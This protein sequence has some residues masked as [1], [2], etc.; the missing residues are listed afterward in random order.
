MCTIPSN[1]GQAKNDNHENIRNK[2]QNFFL[3]KVWRAD[4]IN[5]FILR[6]G[7]QVVRQGSA[8]AL[9][10]GSIPTH[11]SKKTSVKKRLFFCGFIIRTSPVRFFVAR[12]LGIDYQNRSMKKLLCMFLLGLVGNSLCV[13]QSAGKWTP[14]FN[15]KNLEGWHVECKQEDREKTFW[16]VEDGAIVANSMGD[17]KHNYFWLMSDKEFS[18]FELQLKFQTVSDSGNS[19]LQFRSRYDKERGWL[20][21]PQV[22]IHPGKGTEWRTGLIYDETRGVNRWIFPSLKDAG[23][24]K[25][26]KPA[27]YIFKHGTDEWNDLTLICD[28]MKIKTIVNGIVRTDWDAT[29]VLDTEK[30]TKYDVGARGHFALQIHSGDQVHMRFKD[31]KIKPIIKKRK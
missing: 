23:I 8:K 29:G 9:F 4:F 3:D 16:K 30:H 26:H 5:N 10:V 22:D 31:I 14:L 21:G 17:K 18:D 27:E 28:G 11:A 19:G 25:E 12:G 24:G 2:L 6:H 1:A 7:S 15:G 20:N 13:A